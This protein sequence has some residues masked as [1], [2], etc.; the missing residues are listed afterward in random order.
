MLPRTFCMCG[1]S[2]ALS[3]KSSF[4]EVCVFVLSGLLFES[5]QLHLT[6]SPYF[7]S[8]LQFVPQIRGQIPDIS[9]P[10]PPPDVY[11]KKIYQHSTLLSHYMFFSLS[12]VTMITTTQE[13]GAPQSDRWALLGSRATCCR[14][15][16]RG[17][18]GKTTASRCGRRRPRVQDRYDWGQHHG[19]KRKPLRTARV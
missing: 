9:V 1:L 17:S 19:G 13:S 16:R 7:V 15:G 11:S 10:P 6:Y 14:V 2:C 3:V 4:I 5:N 12:I 18:R 8:S